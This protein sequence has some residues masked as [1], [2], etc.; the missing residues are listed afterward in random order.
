MEAD[1]SRLARLET[2]VAYIKEK[3]SSL[4]KVSDAITRLTA[5]DDHHREAIGRAF[6][7]IEKVEEGHEKITA[8]LARTQLRVAIYV[9]SVSAFIA[10]ASAVFTVIAWVIKNDIVSLLQSVAPLAR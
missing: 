4:D 5:A 2:D 1:Q 3:V 7:R 8:E 6:D 9:A 10:G